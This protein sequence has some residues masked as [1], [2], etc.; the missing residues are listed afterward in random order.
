M[1]DNTARAS[2]IATAANESVP[3]SLLTIEEA[4]R[5]LGIG[6]RTFYN[7]QDRGELASL[8]VIRIAGRVKIDPDSL[9]AWIDEHR[10]DQP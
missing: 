1:A 4:C 7:L 8:R 6:R 9:E 3:K 10:V 2:T 5:R